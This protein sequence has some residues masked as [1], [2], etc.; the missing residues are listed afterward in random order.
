MVKGNAHITNEAQSA[1][2]RA[3]L[4][5]ANAAATAKVRA[6]AEAESGKTSATQKG[7]ASTDKS[8]KRKPTEEELTAFARDLDQNMID[9]AASNFRRGLV[10]SIVVV[11]IV[12]VIIFAAKAFLGIEV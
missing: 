1:Q 10:A 9:N 2:K 7:K 3:N 4:A 8:G 11:I 5:S 6:K 12:V